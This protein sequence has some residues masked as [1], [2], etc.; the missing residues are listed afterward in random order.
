LN[1]GAN[2]AIE[3]RCKPRVDYSVFPA[4]PLAICAFLCK[5]KLVHMKYYPEAAKI[6]EIW[7]GW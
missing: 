6:L 2:P 7:K 5:A 1:Q 4:K 3:S